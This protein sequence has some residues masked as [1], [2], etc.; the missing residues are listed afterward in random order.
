MN[1]QMWTRLFLFL[2]LGGLYA[3]RREAPDWSEK[4]RDPRLF[5]RWERVLS[6]HYLEEISTGEFA[7][8]GEQPGVYE[9]A[10]DGRVCESRDKPQYGLYHVVGDSIH[11]YYPTDW[12]K[13]NRDHFWA[14]RYELRGDSL[15]LRHS[16]ELMGARRTIDVYYIRKPF[17]YLR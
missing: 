1:I 14:I 2:A 7:Q 4:Y 8:E 15:V 10:S 12:L 17:Q 5:A 9:F 6:R 16:S 11:F 13:N 3:C